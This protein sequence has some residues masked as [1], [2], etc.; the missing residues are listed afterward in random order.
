MGRE[1]LAGEADLSVTARR[2]GAGDAVPGG[3]PGI[4]RTPARVLRLWIAPH[5]DDDGDHVGAQHIHM[6]VDV[7]GW[8]AG[9]PAP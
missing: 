5:V 8:T 1:D 6:V 3:A 7:G 4:R 2:P 9:D